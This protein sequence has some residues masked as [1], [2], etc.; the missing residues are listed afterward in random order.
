MILLLLYSYFIIIIIII[1]KLLNLYTIG[2]NVIKSVE[3][4]LNYDIN[5]TYNFNFN[6]INNY[7]D[8]YNYATPNDNNESVWIY[9]SDAVVHITNDRS[10]LT[11]FKK[12]ISNL[13]CAN[14]SEMELE[15]F[16]MACTEALLTVIT[17][18]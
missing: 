10:L 8:N 7:N 12:Y 1:I 4:N 15:G 13:T 9:D 2:S 16:G 5:S 3:K 14:N 17:L 6:Y 11:N 18:L